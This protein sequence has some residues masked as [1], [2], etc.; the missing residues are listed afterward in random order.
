MHIYIHSNI[1]ISILTY[2]Y[3][4]THIFIHTY[5]HYYKN[6]HIYVHTY[7]H[8]Q[9]LT[10]IKYLSLYL[11]TQIYSIYTN[12]HTRKKPNFSTFPKQLKTRIFFHCFIVVPFC[13]SYLEAQTESRPPSRVIV[14][15]VF[16]TTLSASSD[17]TSETFGFKLIYWSL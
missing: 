15:F 3:T 13:S 16:F 7:I 2:I 12:S 6:I 4:Y 1:H 14:H 11:Y 10:F 17:Q 5:I 9:N 8:I